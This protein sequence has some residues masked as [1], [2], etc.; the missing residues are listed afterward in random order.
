MNFGLFGV[1]WIEKPT[2]TMMTVTMPIPTVAITPIT[3]S[4]ETIP[5][6]PELMKNMAEEEIL[7]L[8]VEECPHL[9]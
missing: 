3:T 8:M 5:S 9:K 2:V 1:N 7:D 4:P 6:V